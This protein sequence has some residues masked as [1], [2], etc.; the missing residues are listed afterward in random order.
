MKKFII[1][2]MIAFM[3]TNM[4]SA[5]SAKVQDELGNNLVRLHIIAN[6]NSS[7]DQQI[8]LKIRD[9][10]LRSEGERLNCESENTCVQTVKERLHIIEDIANKTLQKNGFSYTAH[11]QYGS[12]EFPQK[13][14]KNMILP[15]GRYYGV[16]IVL[17]EGIGENWWCVMY[18]PLCMTIDNEAVLGEKSQKLLEENLSTETYDVITSHNGEINVKFRVVELAGK[19]K[20]YVEDIAK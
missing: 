10:I 4:I 3:L 19:I 20:K 6:S 14:Y 17:G 15:A 5:Y 13:Q 7:A 8:K 1:S 18:P 2:V 12:F 11:A 9:E 16:R